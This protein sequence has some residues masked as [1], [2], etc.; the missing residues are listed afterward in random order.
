MYCCIMIHKWQY[1]DI[2]K[3]CIITTLIAGYFQTEI[4]VGEANFKIQTV[5]ILKIASFKELYKK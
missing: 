2:S 5:K 4:F 3:L 1:I